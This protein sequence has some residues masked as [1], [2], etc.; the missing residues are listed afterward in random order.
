MGSGDLSTDLAFGILTPASSVRPVGGHPAQ[1]DTESKAR[2]R[3]R[4]EDENGDADPSS[5]TV[6]PSAH[7]LDDLA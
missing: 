1:R 6:D 5:E 4:P 7:Q 3:P 2:R